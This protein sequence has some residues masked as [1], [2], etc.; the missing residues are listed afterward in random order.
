MSTTRNIAAHIQKGLARTPGLSGGEGAS[1]A[2]EEKELQTGGAWVPAHQQGLLVYGSNLSLS[3][4]PIVH[5]DV[6]GDMR[7]SPKVLAEG[8]F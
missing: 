1:G 8:L 2:G 3:P 6:H 4:D 5:W 7:V